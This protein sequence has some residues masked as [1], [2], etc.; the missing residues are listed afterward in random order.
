MNTYD[1]LLPGN[2]FSMERFISRDDVARFAELSG[3]D[4]PIHLDDAA[5]QSLGF[6]R[7]IVHGALLM[8][9]I[10][11]VLGRDYPGPGCVAVSLSSKFL[12]PVPVDSLVR[13]EVKVAER[14]EARK[15]V[16][17]QVYAYLNGKMTMGGEA[18]LVPP[19]S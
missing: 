5:A 15:H 2:D 12:R 4:N 9:F 1:T 8:S 18:V 10:S 6:P 16:R 11:K 3:D 13:F 7:A 14:I 19:K 17:F